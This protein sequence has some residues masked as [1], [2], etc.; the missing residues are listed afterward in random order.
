MERSE[1]KK[2]LT[3]KINKSEQELADKL[4]L[5]KSMGKDFAVIG[6]IV[7]AAFAV[8]KLVAGDE[9]QK[10]KDGENEDSVI[11]STLKGVALSVALAF[12][13]DKLV[14]FIDKLNQEKEIETD[15]K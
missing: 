9:S 5:V 3:Q 6:G 10:E 13:K 14:D 2:I 8:M 12:A 15:K 1:K 4:A 11:F 7:V